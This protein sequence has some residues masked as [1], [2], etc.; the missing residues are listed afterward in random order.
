MKR[1]LPVLLVIVPATV[2]LG[3]VAHSH[4]SFN[5][6]CKEILQKMFAAI[7]DGHTFRYKITASERIEGKMV[8]A[9]SELK[10]QTAPRKLYFKNPDTGVELLYSDGVNN[11]MAL[12]NPNKFPNFSLSLDP[13]GN[14]MRKNQHHTIHELGFAFIGKTIATTILKDPQHV[15]DYFSCTDDVKWNGQSCYKLVADFSKGYKYLE[16]KTSKN[17]SVS[18]IALKF[19]VPDYKIRSKNDL[20]TYYGNI[21]PG[22]LLSI[23]NFYC[24]KTVLY[25]H[26]QL[27]L[28]VYVE[29]Y[30]DE[31]LYETYE[32]S[33]IQV[34]TVISDEEFSRKF[35]TYHF[36]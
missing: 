22:T 2:A 15:N 35:A 9:R 1:Y 36:K 34:N 29:A 11:N 30:D 17:E 33:D 6:G 18:S 4:S 16:Y 26:K 10:L 27:H 3:F 5:P 8:K 32:F 31:G 20:K 19:G 23:P 12:V 21:K 7:K 28:P 25:I 13:Y 14:I 24:K